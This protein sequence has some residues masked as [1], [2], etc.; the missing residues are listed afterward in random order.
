METDKLIFRKQ[1]GIVSEWKL[2]STDIDQFLCEQQWNKYSYSQLAV[3]D[4]EWCTGSRWIGYSHTD[5]LVTSSWPCHISFHWHSFWPIPHK[6]FLARCEIH[7]CCFNVTLATFRLKRKQ[8]HMT[9]GSAYDQF[10]RRRAECKLLYSKSFILVWRARTAHLI[11]NIYLHW[12]SC[13]HS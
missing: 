13:T 12:T 6:S 10:P 2:V 11:P 3:A 8:R 7:R 4:S 5:W 1:S 9:T